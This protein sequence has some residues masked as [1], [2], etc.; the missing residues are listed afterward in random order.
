VP[1][2]E[3]VAQGYELSINRYKQVIHE[4]VEHRQPAEILVELEHIEAKIQQGMSE[5]KAMLG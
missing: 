1:K 5:L 3:I 4:E 2:E